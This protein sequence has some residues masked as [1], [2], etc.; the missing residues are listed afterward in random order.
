MRSGSLTYIPAG[1]SVFFK[2]FLSDY[3]PGIFKKG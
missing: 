3:L 1:G 2:L